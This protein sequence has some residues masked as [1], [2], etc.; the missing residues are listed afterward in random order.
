[1]PRSASS[2][3]QSAAPSGDATDEAI[4]TAAAEPDENGHEHLDEAVPSPAPA[5]AVWDG[6]VATAATEAAR[7]ALEAFAQPPAAVDAAAWWT[8]L[9]RTLSSAA[10]PIYSNVDP[11]LVP[12]TQVVQVDPAQQAGS[13]LLA[14]VT[15]TTDAGT[16]NVLLSRADGASPWLVEQLRPRET[17]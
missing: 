1:V 4:H 11:R 10:V 2:S 16:Y 17:P 15:A 3:S 5:P 6:Q 9:Q 12:Y 13:D 14:S 7:G 8:A